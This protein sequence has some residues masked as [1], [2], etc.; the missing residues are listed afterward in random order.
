[1]ETTWI[2]ETVWVPPVAAG[3]FDASS[4][5]LWAVAAYAAGLIGLV[6][7]GLALRSGRR[8]RS[9]GAADVGGETDAG[10]SRS[11][12]A[13]ALGLVAT[14]VGV[15]VVATADGGVGSG[16]GVGGGIVAIG[17]GLAGTV[18]GAAARVHG[19]TVT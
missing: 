19:R 17:L 8:A 2:L 1:M 4:G 9:N 13:I 12:A 16:N 5:R 14:V 11:T 18:V 10:R 6:I 3:V 15:V 7:G